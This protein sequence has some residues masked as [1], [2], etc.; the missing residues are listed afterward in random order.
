MLL[1]VQAGSLKVQAS[2]ETETETEKEEGNSGVRQLLGIRGGAKEEVRLPS[3]RVGKPGPENQRRNPSLTRH[4]FPGL[5]QLR[6][7]SFT[8]KLSSS[9]R[10]VRLHTASSCSLSH[11]DL[12]AEYLEDPSAAHKARDVGP[13][14]LGSA[15]RCSSLRQGP[16]FIIPL[17]VPVTVP[18]AVIVTAIASV[19]V[20]RL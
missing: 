19:T 17:T 4:T 1:V 9:G 3:S 12:R 5:L 7:R 20:T 10:A 16:H 14:H 18:L 8:A 6:L 2:A 13:T 11:C 15:L